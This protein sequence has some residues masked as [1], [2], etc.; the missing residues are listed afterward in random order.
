MYVNFADLNRACPK[1]SYL[2]SEIDELIDSTASYE[3]LSIMNTFS[4]YHQIPLAK[5][6][7]EKTTFIIDS[8]Y[9]ATV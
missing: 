4:G 6:Y 2:L 1:D 7:Q 5:E 3:L 9:T 8:T